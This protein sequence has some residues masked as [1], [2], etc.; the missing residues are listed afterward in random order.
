MIFIHLLLGI[1]LGKVYGNYLFFI[2]GSIF[3]DLDHILIIIKNKF[4]NIK[5]IIKTIKFEK[6]FNIKYKT[7]L[8]HSVLGLI[9]FSLIICI[10]DLKGAL[11]FGIAYFIHL[12]ID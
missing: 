2:L 3:P 9:L 11:F 12:L 10:F 6:Q 4:W 7:P 1:I 8:F 5:K